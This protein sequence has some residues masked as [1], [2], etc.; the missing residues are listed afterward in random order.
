MSVLN[1]RCP[2]KRFPCSRC[3][4]KIVNSG[5]QWEI[6]VP[7]YLQWHYMDPVTL[8]VNGSASA[9]PIIVNAPRRLLNFDNE[10]QGDSPCKFDGPV[11]VESA[12]LTSGQSP[13]DF[14]SWVQDFEWNRF[15]Y[16]GWNQFGRLH[17]VIISWEAAEV[18]EGSGELIT[19]GRWAIGLR[20]VQQAISHYGTDENGDPIFSQVALGGIYYNS[21]GV[22]GPFGDFFDVAETQATYYPPDDYKC[23]SLDSTRW[24]R[25][26]PTLPVL[27]GTEYTF[28][29][30][31]AGYTW[32][33][34]VPTNLPYSGPFYP[35]GVGDNGDYYA[36]P[37][38]DVRHIPI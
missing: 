36:P 28:G 32:P 27:I 33:S 19:P 21:L 16:D 14:G 29:T 23:L 31:P 15:L 37:Y 2:R 22:G 13:G 10:I 8:A 4:A 5:L 30:L 17:G 6:S 34:D 26:I 1:K 7:K 35:V 38:V 3:G 9:S 20:I 25:D 12:I 18:D 11:T 24:Y